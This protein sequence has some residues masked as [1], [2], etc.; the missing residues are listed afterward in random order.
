MCSLSDE[1]TSGHDFVAV[2]LLVVSRFDRSKVVGWI[3]MPEKSRETFENLSVQRLGIR[4]LIQ[5][6]LERMKLSGELVSRVRG[7][8]IQ[9][10]TSSAAEVVVSVQVVRTQ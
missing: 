4:F 3:T 2:E 5:W 8:G 1:A 7:I 10:G 6:L 9:G